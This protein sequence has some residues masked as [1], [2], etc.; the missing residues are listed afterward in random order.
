MLSLTCSHKAALH[1]L[2]ARTAIAMKASSG[3]A[4]GKLVY[5][6]LRFGASSG[7]ASVRRGRDVE[8]QG[9]Y[10][11]EVEGGPL[12]GEEIVVDL[13][14]VGPGLTEGDLCCVEMVDESRWRCVTSEGRP[15]APQQSADSN[16][17]WMARVRQLAQPL[18]V[19]LA[20]VAFGATL[21]HSAP[22]PSAE[23]S[24]ERCRRLISGSVE[25]ADR[26]AAEAWLSSCEPSIG[27]EE[28][29][30]LL[31]SSWLRRWGEQGPP[32][33][34]QGVPEAAVVAP[35]SSAE[36]ARRAEPPPGV[37]RA[38][39][40]ELPA[41]FI[42]SG[43]RSALAEASATLER[44]VPLV[45]DADAASCAEVG[46]LLR[47][48]ALNGAFLGTLSP[49]GEAL[50]PRRSALLGSIPQARRSKAAAE[51]TEL[52]RSLRAVD[53]EVCAAN[54]EEA[55]ERLEAAR[56]NLREL[57]ALYYDESCIGSPCNGPTL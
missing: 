10:W 16:A 34:V 39:A 4:Y 51:V 15:A 1:S 33:L 45:A 35:A 6:R 28:A 29:E 31:A 46:R 22:R 47:V 9:G 23:E 36:T 41:S 48:P 43:I 5:G 40:A 37:P 44:L 2:S 14:D 24:L 21:S 42:G 25:A 18:A 12:D 38:A 55:S 11:V 57:V 53:A 49:D 13:E 7:P 27:R 3:P 19:I 20:T 8:W 50:R 52:L 26:R 54:P 32:R 30:S 17:F 56:N